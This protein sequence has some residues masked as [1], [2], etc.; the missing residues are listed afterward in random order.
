MG[1]GE[2]DDK[3][4]GGEG[5]GRAIVHKLVVGERCPVRMVVFLKSMVTVSVRKVAVQP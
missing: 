2:E 3:E 1:A 4:G 5:G